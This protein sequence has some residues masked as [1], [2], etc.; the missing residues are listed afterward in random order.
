MGRND[1]N[2][3]GFGSSCCDSVVTNPTSIG[4]DT[5]LIPDPPQWVKELAQP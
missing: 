4:E 2:E 1:L 3:K 5:G